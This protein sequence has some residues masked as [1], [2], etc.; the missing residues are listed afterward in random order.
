MKC[1]VRKHFT[2]I[3]LLVVI[4]I[5]A[6]LASI[7]MPALS[8]ARERART[9]GC[10][11]NLKTFGSW[12]HMYADNYDGMMFTSQ[13]PSRGFGLTGTN[14]WTRIDSNPFY[15]GCKVPW[16]VFAKTVLCPADANPNN[17]GTATYKCKSSYG[18]NGSW[19]P[20]DTKRGIGGQQLATLKNPSSVLMMAD[21]AYLDSDVTNDG[22][23]PSWCITWDSTYRKY[24]YSEELV[25]LN[26]IR[27]NARPNLLYVDGHV[28][29]TDR[30]HYWTASGNTSKRDWVIFWYYQNTKP[31]N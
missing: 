13:N 27:H 10:N 22:C 25:A 30:A 21:T 28:A 19:T 16:N 29:P 2:L 11:N 3:E 12:C 17:S 8:Q 31:I 24:L 26:R 6:I 14:R 20:R 5:I 4:A 18:Y 23:A 15:F 1:N 9:S 7:L